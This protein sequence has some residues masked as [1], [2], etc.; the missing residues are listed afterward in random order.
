[1][2]NHTNQIG[3]WN[4][5]NIKFIEFQFLQNNVKYFLHIVEYP[6]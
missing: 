6:K 5:N 2:L 3:H 4:N 1:M